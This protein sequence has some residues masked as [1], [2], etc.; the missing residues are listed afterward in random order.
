MKLVHSSY[1]FLQEVAGVE[2]KLT[3]SAMFAVSLKELMSQA[4]PGRPPRQA[5]RFPT[6]LLAAFED[7]VLSTDKP[8]FVRVLSWWLL[9]QSWGTL[10][11]DDHRGLLPRDF[12]VSATGLQ[13]R[14]TRS[15]VSGSDKH[16]NF[17][18]V[19]IHSSAY[20]QRR[21]W[22]A[23]GWNL[24]LNGAPHERDYL[25]PAPTNN[26]HGFQNQGVEIFDGLRGAN[27]HH[28]CVLLSWFESLREFKGALLHASQRP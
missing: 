9:V 20:V 10:R 5:P 4:S 12:I 28:F 1:I 25:L 11:F 17:R 7:T 3:D 21:D 23:V 19:I 13:A 6:I 18:T 24:L 16:L 22:L 26:F 2:D 14:L 15:K 27:T 8:V